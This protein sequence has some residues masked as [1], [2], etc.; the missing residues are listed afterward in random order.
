MREIVRTID[1]IL[2]R[3]TMYRVVVYGLVA[4]LSIAEVLALTGALSIS[5]TGLL[6]S[7]LALVASCYAANHL[8]S[9]GLH[10]TANTESW[11]ITA[12]IL[13]CIL[14]P[15]TSIERFGMVMLAGVIAMA[16]KYLLVH[17]GTHIFN[18][19]AIAAFIMSITGL[20]PATWWI[21][22]PTMAAFS[23]LLALAVLRKIRMFT[24]F[25][26]FGIAAGAML[27][28]VSGFLNGQEWGDVIKSA[29]LSWP[30]IFFGSI[31]LSEPTTL[32]P[33]RYYQ[34][35]Y[36]FLVGGIFGSQ[37][38]IG[39]VS[40][41]PQAALL[42]GNLFTLAF[43]PSFGAMLKLK[44][45]R[46][47]AADIYEAV[48]ERPKQLSFAAGQYV[49]WTLPHKHTDSRGNRRIFSVASSPTEPDIRIG[50]R[51]YEHSSSFKTALLGLAPG[52]YIRAAHVA[53]NFTLPV[54]KPE[55][56]LFVAGGIGITPFRS[57]LQYLLDTG[58]RTDVVL[59]YFA[60]K[61]EDFVYTDLLQQAQ[62]IGLVTHYIT[63]RPQPGILERVVP[64]V[65][66]RTIYL[67][68][69]DALVSY[70]K[71]SLLDLHISSEQIKTDHFTGY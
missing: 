48:F 32:P 61:P 67:S 71:Q 58:Q 10:A 63:G 39:G 17:R 23:V 70:H 62:D 19:V 60:A 18:P 22:N 9:W 1:G 15:V 13:A 12:L 28:F 11:L 26:S 8:L 37:L 57:M 56:L 29:A 41:S 20:L 55:P 33:T 25:I 24:L 5:A 51:H 2:N 6:L 30:I 49:E 54:D 44:Q 43:V 7:V 46:P 27:L 16:S 65:R 47:L 3:Y 69:P 59:V 31:M 4:L 38:H 42:I 53:G 52:K 21:A 45:L 50:F 36:A 66:E 34:V 40:S 35:L 14:P 64:D 68:G